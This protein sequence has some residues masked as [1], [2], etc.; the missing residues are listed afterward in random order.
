MRQLTFTQAR[1]IFIKRL[2]LRSNALPTTDILA[3]TVICDTDF[4][5]VYYIYLEISDIRKAIAKYVKLGHSDDT[6]DAMKSF[7]SIAN[8]MDKEILS[9]AVIDAI[10]DVSS[11]LEQDKIIGDKV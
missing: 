3:E 1:N 6:I 11:V 2:K 4:L 8:K 9:Q 7:Y 5:M 10:L